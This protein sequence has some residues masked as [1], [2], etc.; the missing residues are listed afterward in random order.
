[1]KPTAI[2]RLTQLLAVLAVGVGAVQAQ[3]TAW[4]P[5]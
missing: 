3:E 1:M 2:R 4:R 5:R